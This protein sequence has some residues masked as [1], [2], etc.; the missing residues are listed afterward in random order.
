MNDSLNSITYTELCRIDGIEREFISAIVEY[1]IVTPKNNTHQEDWLFETTSVYWIKK[2]SRLH[3]DLE[4]DWIAVALVI[5]LLQKQ[6][7]L[8][9]E[10]QRINRLLQRF[11]DKVEKT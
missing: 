10:N 11:V 3:I 5:E 2:A 1:G 6:R 4:I 9:K 8:E 7:E